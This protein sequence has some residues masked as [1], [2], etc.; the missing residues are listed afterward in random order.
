MVIWR[1]T[2]RGDPR[3][4]KNSMKI[5]GGKEKCPRCHKPLEQWIRQGNAHDEWYEAASWQLTNKPREPIDVPV[6]CKY[7]FYIATDRLVDVLNLEAAVDDL[8]V[9]NKILKD[10]NRKIV[11]HHDGSRVYVDRANPRVEIEITGV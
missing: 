9:K 4:K 10:D 3:T 2:I 1:C 7:T 8:L 6:Q 11:V 5:A